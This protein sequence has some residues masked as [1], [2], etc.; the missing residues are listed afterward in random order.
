MKMIKLAYPTKNL[1]DCL[2][3]YESVFLRNPLA[4]P[5]TGFLKH[6]WGKYPIT[7]VFLESVKIKRRFPFISN[8]YFE[9]HLTREHLANTQMI[10]GNRNEN[11]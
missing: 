3:Y 7:I 5:Y 10:L 11:D 2:D 9:F 6:F 1:R 8:R 4:T